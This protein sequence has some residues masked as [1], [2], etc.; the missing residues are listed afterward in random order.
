MIS[1]LTRSYKFSC[2]PSP[3]SSFEPATCALH[4]LE[5]PLRS[6][7]IPCPGFVYGV[8]LFEI[9]QYHISLSYSPS[10]NLTSAL[11]LLKPRYDLPSPYTTIIHNLSLRP[12]LAIHPLYIPIL[13]AELSIESSAPRISTACKRLDHLERVAGQHEW[14]DIMQGDPLGLD[15]ES[16][17]KQLNFTSRWLSMEIWRYKSNLLVLNNVKS[18]IDLL[19]ENGDCRDSKGRELKELIAYHADTCHNL[20]LKAE[21]QENRLQTQIAVVCR[22]LLL[23]LSPSPMNK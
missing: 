1:T 11:L 18:E 23:T 3:S 19:S 6:L 5:S 7:L 12:S 4:T 15:F 21:F 17:S 13:L 16:A 9:G 14:T 10:Q 8:A 22:P 20:I 2:Y